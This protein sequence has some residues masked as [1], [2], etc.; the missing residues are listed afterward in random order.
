MQ[1]T[2]VTAFFRFL[3]QGKGYRPVSTTDMHTGGSFNASYNDGREAIEVEISAATN[4][5]VE[6]CDHRH[7]WDVDGTVTVQDFPEVGDSEGCSAR[8]GEGVVANLVG[9][10]PT[11]RRSMLEVAQG[12]ELFGE[13]AVDG[14]VL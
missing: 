14:D 13:L 3:N 8:A 5:C 6:F 7:A 2:G 9:G 12:L 4:N 10:S 11:S 1:P